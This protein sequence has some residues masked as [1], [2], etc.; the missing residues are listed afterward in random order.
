MLGLAASYRGTMQQAITKVKT[1][2]LLIFTFSS[3]LISFLA[4]AIWY[5]DFID[6]FRSLCLRNLSL[7]L[8]FST[9]HFFVK[10]IFLYFYDGK[11]PFY[12]ML[13]FVYW[14]ISSSC[15]ASMRWINV[16]H[17]FSMPIVLIFSLSSPYLLWMSSQRTWHQV[18]LKISS[19]IISVQIVDMDL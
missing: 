4:K 9:S 3:V 17:I 15:F 12:C 1:Y 5:A 18:Y 11:L 13:Y 7:L 14:L 16:C 2:N 6:G 10:T 19:W 8:T